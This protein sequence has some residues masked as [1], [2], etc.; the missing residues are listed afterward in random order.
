MQGTGGHGILESISKA[1]NVV[2]RGVKHLQAKVE[3]H[4]WDHGLPLEVSNWQS[5]KAIDEKKTV[6][7]RG[8]DDRRVGSGD[9]N[10]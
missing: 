7:K 5:V 2:R 6:D 8:Y 10:S 9:N 3:N 4:E 1:I